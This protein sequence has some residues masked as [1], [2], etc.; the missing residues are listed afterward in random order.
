MDQVGSEPFEATVAVGQDWHFVDTR[1]SVCVGHGRV[2]LRDRQGAVI[3][4]APASDV[5]A[6]RFLEATRIWMGGGHYSVERP[7]ATRWVTSWGL[8][9]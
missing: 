3:V 1:G 5:Y 2:V 9:I 8:D 6:R 4:E 7:K